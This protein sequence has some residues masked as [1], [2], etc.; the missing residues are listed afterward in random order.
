MEIKKI[1]QNKV[2]EFHP[3][4]RPSQSAEQIR[5]KLS[6]DKFELKNTEIAQT[7]SR[8]EKEREAAVVNLVG[9]AAA[10]AASFG[11]GAAGAGAGA[12]GAAGAGAAG[13]GA[14]GAGESATSAN[15]SKEK[16]EKYEIN[17]NENELLKMRLRRV[18]A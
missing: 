2:Q 8:I 14:A 7:E 5:N 10:A 17:N 9:S 1:S 3:E 6:S 16:L 18:R 11:M 13:V 15:D 12:A 4:D